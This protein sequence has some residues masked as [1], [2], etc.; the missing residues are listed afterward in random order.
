TISEKLDPEDVHGIMD[1]AFEVMMAAV[2]R[3][4]GTINQFLG[5]GIMALFGAPIA[6][7]DHPHRG[8][9]TAL[10]IREGLKPLQDDVRR[11]HGVEFRVRMGL[12]TGVVVVG[13]IGGDLRMDYTAVGDTTNLTARLMALAQPGQ[14]V[15]SGRTQHLRERFFRW[16]DLGE[17]QV[18]GKKEPVHAFSLLDEIRG[19]T[20][21]EVSKERG[22]TP[23]I[24]REREVASLVEMYR[25]AENGHGAV[26]LVS[27]EPGVGKSRLIYE[28]I[29]AIEIA[30]GL[31]LEASCVAYGR[32]TPYRP[33]LEL[34]RGY[35]SLLEDM[36][37]DEVRWRAEKGLLALGIEGDEP[38]TLLAH[39]LGAP[40]PEAFLNRLAGAQLKA[41]TFEVVRDLLLR[42][43][44]S[45][46][47]V[48]VLENIHW[49][50][51]T[52]EEF[53]SELATHVPSHRIVLVLTT[54]PGTTAS[55][56]AKRAET[57]LALGGLGGAD[58]KGMVASL[59][60]ADKVSEELFGILLDKSAGNP[61]Y[62]EE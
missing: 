60:R 10:A 31:E 28:F 6:H 17:F 55:A 13:A 45:A 12:N 33:I 27:G 39:F 21:L 22:L 5:D 52:S 47:L 44:E 15:V 36:T 43:S 20:R 3:Y 58:L 34:V 57:T 9:C 46:P 8:L 26:V 37:Q 35:L 59:V 53:L 40:A 56:L 24:G 42:A 1:R 54:R 19:Q 16:E 30:G 11:A 29:R 50:D 51:T 49:I 48:L 41:R 62:I 32:T 14:I 23:L 61:L 38:A 2:H 7:E 4:E 25:G 18:K